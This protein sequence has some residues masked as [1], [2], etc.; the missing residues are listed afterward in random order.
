VLPRSREPDREV[1]YAVVGFLLCLEMQ[2]TVHNLQFA[3]DL[4]YYIL[5]TKLHD[6]YSPHNNIPFITTT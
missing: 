5:N 3:A 2:K 6:L 4:A 1:V